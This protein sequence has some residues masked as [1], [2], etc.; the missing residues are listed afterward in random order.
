MPNDASDV[1]RA[2]LEG[3]VTAVACAQSLHIKK[4][5]MSLLGELSKNV[6][7]LELR[8]VPLPVEHKIA[9]TSR[10]A[11]VWLED[12]NV[13]KWC[14]C[15]KMQACQEWSFAA[16]TFGDVLFQTDAEPLQL[17]DEEMKFF[18]NTVHQTVICDGFIRKMSASEVDNSRAKEF[19]SMLKQALE[20]LD[21]ETSLPGVNAVIRCFRGLL[22]LSS[23][24]P[25]IGGSS[26]EDVKFVT[27]ASVR[28]GL[29]GR[30]VTILTKLS[31][32]EVGN[33]RCQCSAY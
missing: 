13:L 1:Y 2:E 29:P 14:S 20:V 28:K 32:L 7:Y 11:T 6:A 17:S 3:N 31:T 26:L 30:G 21:V 23:P 8:G 9:I 19:S 25:G 5:S 24:I 16:P 15:L 22:A 12:G 10:C 33:G 18:E 4:I 27:T